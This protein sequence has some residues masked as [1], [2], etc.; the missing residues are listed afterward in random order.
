MTACGTLLVLL[1]GAQLVP[2]TQAQLL[3]SPI[4]DDSCVSAVLAERVEALKRLGERLKLL[5]AHDAL[6]L[7]QKCFALP[8]LLYTLRTAPCFRSANLAA[9]DDCLREILGLVTNTFLERDSS[10]WMQV[11][12]PVKLGGLGI[13]SAVSVAPSAFLASTY[14]TADLVDA[15][16]PAHFRSHPV[17]HLNEAQSL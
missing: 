7:L 8:K 17:P 3:G 14:F 15:I 4:G 5:S 16:L 9:Y 6:I 1:P 11:T 12:L 13:R 2:P 10:A